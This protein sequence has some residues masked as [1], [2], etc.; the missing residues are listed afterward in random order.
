AVDIADDAL[1]LPLARR[2]QL[3]KVL[4][5][6]RIEPVRRLALSGETLQPDAVG[7][8]KVVQGAVHRLE[9]RPAI[10]AVI[11]IGELRCDVVDALVAPRIV[12]R[13]HGEVRFHGELPPFALS[14]LAGEGGE[15][16][17]PGKGSD[18]TN[19]S[20]LPTCFAGH[21]LPQR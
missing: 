19:S 1:V 15:R 7:D 17:E 8:E 9:E 3:G 20:P 10:R 14:P 6:D 4:E 5:Q 13:Y 21:P 16:S 12:A 18:R 2:T 11:R